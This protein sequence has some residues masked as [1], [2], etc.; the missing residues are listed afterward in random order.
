MM[1]NDVFLAA[2][3]LYD[4][5]SACPPCPG[6]ADV[7]LALG[8]HDLR[9]PD[10]AASLYLA[11]ASPII[12]CSGGYGKMTEGAFP[13][14][15][16]VLFAEQCRQKGIPEDRILIEDKATNTGENFS[17]S[18]RLTQG[19]AFKTGIAVCKPY[20]AKRAWATGTMQWPEIQWSVSVPLIPFAQYAPDEAALIPEI[21]LM[22]GDLQRLQVYA[23]K[24]Y[25]APVNVP[26]DIWSA[27]RL[28]VKTGF[29]R[30]VL[31]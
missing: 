29:D 2:K 10:H 14:P 31:S 20:M 11:G 3:R 18:K 7:I 22:V 9:V 21:E 19:R 6:R 25:Q 27:W 1:K 16:G 5:M 24:G 28:L 23:E 26:N 4:F 30:Y 15:E 8:S 13:K 12:I 17:F